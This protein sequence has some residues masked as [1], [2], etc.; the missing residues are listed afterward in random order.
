MNILSLALA[1]VVF[2]GVSHAKVYFDRKEQHKD[3]VLK[4]GKENN[5]RTYHVFTKRSLPY[6]APMI[7]KSITNF[8]DRCNNRLMNKREF[9][10]K[11]TPCKYHHSNIIESFVVKDL[12]PGWLSEEGESERY[13]LG[14]RTYN[15][16]TSSYY[17]LVQ[18]FAGKN[19]HGQKTYTVIERMLNDKE[20]TAFT[21]PKMKLETPYGKREVKFILTEISPTETQMKY[22]LEATTS[23]WLMNKELLVPQVFGTIT[24]SINDLVAAIAIESDSQ[25]RS[26]ASEHN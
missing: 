21:H 10:D 17:E 24:K 3:L 8:T 13:L 22:V 7:L 25:S 9:M 12:N 11:T 2:S 6:S 5:E 26:L 18:V 20:V 4:T 1:F 15:R 14:R 19:K 23:H 16:E